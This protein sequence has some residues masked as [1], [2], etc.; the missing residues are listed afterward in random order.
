MPAGCTC[1]LVVYEPITFSTFRV[2]GGSGGAG[3]GFKATHQ[4]SFSESSP[5]AYCKGLDGTAGSLT[6][7]IAA[8]QVSGSW[9]ARAQHVN[10][11]VPL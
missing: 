4:Q 5:P 11:Q 3:G 1:T 2:A 10:W 9:A 7:L 8:Q 6:D